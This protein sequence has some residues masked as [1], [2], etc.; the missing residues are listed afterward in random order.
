MGTQDQ[1][2][3]QAERRAAAAKAKAVRTA[4]IGRVNP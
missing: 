2:L 3:A 1:V 4:G